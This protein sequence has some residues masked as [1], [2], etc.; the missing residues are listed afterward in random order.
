M[1][2]I[3]INGSPKGR[4]STSKIM[5]DAFTKYLDDCDIVHIT[6]AENDLQHC[7]GCYS[8][9][10]NGSGCVID[11]DF[12]KIFA[13]ADGAN[14]IV[15]ASPVYFKNVTGLFKNFIDRLTSTGSPHVEKTGESPKFVML[16][17]CG[18]PY[19]SEF[20]VI[21]LWIKRFSASMNSPLLGE[22]YFPGG[23]R[24]KEPTGEAALYLDN[25]SQ[26]GKNIVNLLKES[27]QN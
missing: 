3:T 5:I 9:W 27:A 1:K 15:F 7:Q 25:L 11:D 8:C 23:K 6:L 16:S 24:L 18:F 26:S 14:L 10:I 2:I 4:D 13:L 21:S 17:N 22:F 12:G 20:E 19:E